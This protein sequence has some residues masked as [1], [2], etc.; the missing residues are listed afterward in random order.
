MF[1]GCAALKFCDARASE[2]ENAKV[3]SQYQVHTNGSIITIIKLIMK[4]NSHAI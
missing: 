1:N 4:H 2:S 3:C